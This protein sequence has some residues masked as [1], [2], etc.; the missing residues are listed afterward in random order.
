MKLL[1]IAALAAACVLETG[2]AV[3]PARSRSAASADECPPGHRWSD[4]RCHSTGKGHDPDKH[5]K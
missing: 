3:V 1:A 2:C 5:R 4:G